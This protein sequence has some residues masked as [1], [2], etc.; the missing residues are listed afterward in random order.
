VAQALIRWQMKWREH[1]N[2]ERGKAI[3]RR[4][5]GRWRNREASD[6]VR[7]WHAKQVEAKQRG[8]GEAIMRRVGGRW[9]HKELAMNFSEWVRNYKSHLSGSRARLEDELAT[10]KVKFAMVTQGGAE[11]IMRNVA[12]RMLYGEVAQ[13]LIRW[14]MKWREHA[15]AERGKAIMRRVGGRWRNREAS[16]AIKEWITNLKDSKV[17]AIE[18]HSA[19]AMGRILRRWT[20]HAKHMVFKNWKHRQSK[21]KMDAMREMAES[22]KADTQEESLNMIIN[23]VYR[24]SMKEAYRG[25]QNWRKV[26]ND[27][28]RGEKTRQQTSGIMRIVARRIVEL[29]VTENVDLKLINKL[30]QAFSADQKMAAELLKL[31]N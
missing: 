1:A 23:I 20:T 3:M 4:V 14:Q 18:K 30:M 6:A 24:W 9:L 11:Q 27:S 25:I 22:I 28:L 26:C 10:L 8:R 29:A 21:E 12:K 13:A 31:H 19:R 15:N 17:F 16:D 5:G 7:E 2:A